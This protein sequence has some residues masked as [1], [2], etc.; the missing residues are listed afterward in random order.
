MDLLKTPKQLLMEE[1]GAHST[2]EGLLITPQ[3]KLME[4]TG[5]VPKFAK[6][7]KVTPLKHMQAE[8]LIEKTFRPHLAA[9]GQPA[10]HPELAKAWNNLFK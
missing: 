8:L 5:I 6:G 7:K 10:L 9:G 4:E 2:G 3:Q 1:A